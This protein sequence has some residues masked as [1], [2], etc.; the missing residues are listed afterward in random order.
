MSG[1]GTTDLPSA[2]LVPT[3]ECGKP[4]EHGEK[5]A[6]CHWED[7]Y[8]ERGALALKAIDETAANWPPDIWPEDGEGIDCESASWARHVLSLAKEA[9]AGAMGLEREAA[10][11]RKLRSSILRRGKY[12]R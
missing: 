5:C 1:Q 9:V 3:C 4:A 6:G 2:V 10:A 7:L 11:E 8:C 12:P